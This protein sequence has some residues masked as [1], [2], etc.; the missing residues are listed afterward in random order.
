M[1]LELFIARKVYFG[2]STKQKVSSPAIKIAVAGIAIGLAAMVLS[3]CIVVGFK[4]E[5]RDKVIGFGSHIQITS[6]ANTASYDT[7]PVRLSDSLLSVLQSNPNIE[8]I[9]SYA[10]KPGIIKTDTDFQGVVLK[11]VGENYDWSF[12]KD[13]MIEG[14]VFQPSDST[15]ANQA[16][17]SKY[18]ADRLHLKLGDSFF[19]YF[20]QDP[21]KVRKFTITGIYSTNFEDYDK[22]FMIVGLNTV[23]RLNSWDANQV[24]GLELR[25][26]DYSRLQEVKDDLFFQMAGSHDGDGNALF[27]RSI[28]DINPMIFSWLSLLDMNV[29]VI[30]ILMLA[31]SGFTMISGLLIIILERANMIGILKALG[32]RN[33]DIRKIFLYISSFLIIKGM[34]WGNVIALVICILQKMFGIIKLDPATYYVTEMPVYLNPL[35]II[36]INIG[37]L[38]ISLAMMIGPSYLIA[39]I[40]PAKSIKFE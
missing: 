27:T 21:P 31:V 34:I 2:E 25:V 24:S 11:G 15:V 39:R 35:Y 37:A 26:K 28:E 16:I 23:Q 7:K 5:I 29:W 19:S 6:F 22:L 14:D 8:H 20:I 30:I 36:L 13:N 38:L 32:C 4:K 9:E 40:S 3:V 1:N 17:I 12:F 18:I 33:T 10:T